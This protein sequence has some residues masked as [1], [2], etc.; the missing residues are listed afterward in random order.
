MK[1]SSREFLSLAEF[2]TTKLQKL[3]GQPQ[4][5]W[6]IKTIEGQAVFFKAA[7]VKCLDKGR[8]LL[9]DFRTKVFDK[10]WCVPLLENPAPVSSRAIEVPGPADDEDFFG[11]ERG[12]QAWKARKKQS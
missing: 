1:V 3:K 8:D 4:A 12:P 11:P 2:L 9:S 7:F 5:H 6:A 10:P